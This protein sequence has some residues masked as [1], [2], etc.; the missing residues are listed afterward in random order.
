M[1]FK[2]EPNNTITKPIKKSNMSE[3]LDFQKQQIEALQDEVARLKL[4]LTLARLEVIDPI[5][6]EPIKR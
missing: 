6:L 5:F 2:N 3:L 1:D 4:E